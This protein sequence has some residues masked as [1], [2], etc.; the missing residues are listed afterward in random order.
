MIDSLLFHYFNSL[1]LKYLWLD[2]LGIFF[3]KYLPYL[4]FSILFLLLI[5]NFQKYWKLIKLSFLSAILASIF[6]EIVRFLWFRPRPFIVREV[7]LL[8]NH[9]PT[10]A[11]PSMHT[12]F[13]FGLSTLLYFYNRKAGILFL[14]ASF[15]IGLSRVF[16]GLHWPSDI[17]GGIIVGIFSGWLIL[18][19]TDKKWGW[20]DS[21]PHGLTSRGF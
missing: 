4:L 13:F 1:A 5:K 17:L 9:T 8:L 19:L 10:A 15:L 3:A 18:K 21:N 2:A 14:F 6:T 11:F 7:N 20:R 16:C 12:S